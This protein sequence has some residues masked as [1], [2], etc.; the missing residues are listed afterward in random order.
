[1]LER[2]RAVYGKVPRQ[3]SFG[4][5]YASQASVVEAE[6]LGV[7]DVCFSKKRELEI[8]DMAKSTWVRASE[9]FA[10]ASKGWFRTSS[11]RLRAGPL[12]LEGSALLWE[13]CLGLG[14]VGEGGSTRTSCEAAVPSPHGGPVSVR[15]CRFPL[16]GCRAAEC[17][18]C[19]GESCHRDPVG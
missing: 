5:G 16:C 7:R 10:R 13:L 4:G 17:G 2:Q 19:R 8:T 18:L 6:A 14:G 11:V 3:A 9:T 15:A 12:H 1:M